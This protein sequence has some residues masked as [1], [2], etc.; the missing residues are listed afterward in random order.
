MSR[1]EGLQSAGWSHAVAVCGEH[2]SS[3]KPAMRRR[4]VQLP[5]LTGSPA[6]RD[7]GSSSLLQPGVTKSGLHFA[8]MI[9]T[10]V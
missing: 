6:C 5:D 10:S 8:G 7:G 4:P 9:H 1:S 3:I 2:R